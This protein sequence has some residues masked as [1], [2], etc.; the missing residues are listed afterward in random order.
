[1]VSLNYMFKPK[2]KIDESNF[3]LRP[4]VHRQHH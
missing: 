1:M 4:D 3:L 2:E